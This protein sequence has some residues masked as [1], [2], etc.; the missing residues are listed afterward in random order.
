MADQDVTAEQGGLCFNA[1]I[2]TNSCDALT[3]RDVIEGAPNQG[4]TNGKEESKSTVDQGHVGRATAPFQGSHA[5][6]KDFNADEADSGSTSSA[7]Y[8]TRL[9]PGASAL[10]LSAPSS[11]RPSLCRK[12][13]RERRA[14]GVFRKE[15]IEVLGQLTPALSVGCALE[16]AN[17]VLNAEYVKAPGCPTQCIRVD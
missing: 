17:G 11:Y 7:S 8:E 12:D 4:D 13:V 16:N 15:N 14:I 1:S 10:A 2:T 3:M 6:E 9:W 5:R